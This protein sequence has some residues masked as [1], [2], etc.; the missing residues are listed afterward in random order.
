[1]VILGVFG[2]LVKKRVP[3]SMFANCFTSSGEDP[4]VKMIC[5]FFM[6]IPS[7]LT[8]AELVIT[9]EPESE[10]V[11]LPFTTVVPFEIS[12]TPDPEIIR[13]PFRTSG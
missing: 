5:P 11:R 1:M 10:I 13:E 4:G 6:L 2:R 7:T 9:S 3:P 12:N 8:L